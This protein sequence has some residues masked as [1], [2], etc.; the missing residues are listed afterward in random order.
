M[1]NQ[2]HILNGDCLKEQFPNEIA[3][4]T[5]IAR[6]CL[7]DG[8]VEGETLDDLYATRAKFLSQNY[9]GTESDYYKQAVAE[10]NKI[11]RIDIDTDINLWFEDDLFCQ[12]NFWFVA[13][14][15]QKVS[16]RD[17][18]FLVRPVTHTPYGFAGLSQKELV[19]IFDNRTPIT[20]PS[21]IAALWDTY[22]SGDLEKLV[23][24]AREL[25]GEYPFIL[26]AVEAHLERIPSNGSLGRP[27]ESLI[28]IMKELETEKFGPVFMEFN[29]RESIY[30]FGDLQ[31]KRLFGAIKRKG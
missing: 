19:S 9:G 20:K 27:T 12:V 30:G 11:Q 15:L 5:I 8:D 24:L 2:I 29:K 4:D 23:G 22:Q 21:E 3:G 31:V 28:A 26:R 1:R 16:R 17:K 18:V 10:F 13:S 14:L 6:E 7:V 25:K